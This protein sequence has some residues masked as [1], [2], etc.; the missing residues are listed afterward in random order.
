MSWTNDSDERDAGARRPPLVVSRPAQDHPRRARPAAAAGR[1]AGAR[2]RLRF[3]ADA[4]ELAAYG[5][6]QGIELDPGAAEVARVPRAWRGADRPA[7]GAARGRTDTFDLITC[8]DVIEHTPDDRVTLTELRRVSRPGGWLL[9]TVPAYQALWSTARRGQPPLPPLLAAH[10]CGRRH[11]TRAGGCVRLTSFNS[12]LLAPAA[13]VRLAE[14]RGCA[15]RT[16][17]YKPE[18]TLG[19]DMA[20]PLLER[21]LRI[22]AGWLARAAARS[23]P[24]CRCWPCS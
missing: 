7:R 16:T 10:C 2:R 5:E 15:S 12:L 8:L 3:G 4:E 22:E 23:R 18:L 9:V 20:E 1:C 11:A 21:P 13:A 14:R 6:V 17:D 24:G 19:P